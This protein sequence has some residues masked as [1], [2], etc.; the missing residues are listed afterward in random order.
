M[1]CLSFNRLGSDAKNAP[2]ARKGAHGDLSVR[3][4]EKATAG[5]NRVAFLEKTSH[6]IEGLKGTIRI[7]RVLQL[8]VDTV[9]EIANDGAIKISEELVEALIP[10]NIFVLGQLF[11]LLCERGDQTRIGFSKKFDILSECQV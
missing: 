9:V 1:A 11:P 3:S 4:L 8:L 10:R 5:I 7:C 2:D 6:G